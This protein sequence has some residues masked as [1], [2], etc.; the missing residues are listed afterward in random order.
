MDHPRQAGPPNLGQNVAMPFA[1]PRRRA[2][3]LACATLL[4]IA[5]L[6]F[7]GTAAGAQTQTVNTEAALRTAIT[8]GV[9]TIVLSS[10]IEL[11][12][13]GDP[14]VA[15]LQIDSATTLRSNSD[16][17]RTLSLGAGCSDRLIEVTGGVGLTIERLHLTGGRAPDGTVGAAEVSGDPGGNGGNGGAI[18]S[19]GNVTLTNARFSNNEAGDG[20]MGAAGDDGTEGANGDAGGNGGNGGGGGAIFTVG[21]VTATNSTFDNNQAGNGGNGGP[22]GAGDDGAPGT[23]DETTGNGGPG[24]NGGVG[25]NGGDGGNGGAISAATVTLTRSTLNGNSAGDGGDGALGGNGGDGGNGDA[26][27]TEG[28]GGDAGDAA[29]GGDAGNGGSGGAAYSTTTITANTSTIHNNAASGPGTGGQP[30]TAGTAGTLAGGGSD[31]LDSDVVAVA[32]QPGSWGWGGAMSADGNLSIV[33]STVTANTTGDEALERSLRSGGSI[34]LNHSVIAG[35]GSGEDCGA[36]TIT[37]DNSVA[38]DAT[39]D[40]AEVIAENALG[41]NA[42]LDNGGDT[43]TRLPAAN[44][45]LVNGGAAT[46]P[47]TTDQRGVTRPQ[48]GNCDIGAVELRGTVAA[49]VVGDADEDTVE[50]GGSATVTFTITMANTTTGL[51]TDADLVPTI[52]GCTTTPVRGGAAPSWVAGEVITWTCD[53]TSTAIETVNVAFNATIG[54]GEGTTTTLAATVPV[55]FTQVATTTTTPTTTTLVV[56]ATTVPQ[57]GTG[58]IGGSLPNTGLSILFTLAGAAALVGGGSSLTR[59]AKVRAARSP[60]WGVKYGVPYPAGTA[61]RRFED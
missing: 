10:N 28:N 25:G 3:A 49:T 37:A 17:V 18:L 30:G 33:S 13:D 31:G 52:T 57:S 54:T 7:S 23:A 35:T 26:A 34:G 39:C 16:T 14:N 53:V 29:N 36:A 43:R 20:G 27:G 12:C 15:A 6:P 50:V 59:Y 8:D 55:Q 56:V 22:G 61:K 41:L 58:G 32:G 47:A 51:L 60:R 38:G 19:D 5:I 45:D 1:F 21:S 40:D 2:L 44:S 46:C 48:A 42:L 11:T 4:A 9:P 24:T